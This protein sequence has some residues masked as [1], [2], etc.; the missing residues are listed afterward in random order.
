MAVGALEPQFFVA[1]LAG[2]GIDPNTMPFQYDRDGWPGLRERLT[3]V[4]R[5]RTR[6]EWE[7]VFSTLDGCVAPVL[8]MGEAARHPHNRQRGTFVEVGGVTQPAPAPRFD[9]TPAA[10]PTPPVSA[11]AHTDEVLARFGFAADEVAAL[12]ASAVVG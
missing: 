6:A 7:Q 9:R 10:L 1:L 2:L 11:G 5:T 12:R 8:T 4:F 3:A